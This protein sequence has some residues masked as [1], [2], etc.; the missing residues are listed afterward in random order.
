MTDG[1]MN[2]EIPAEAPVEADVNLT[3]AVTPK[4]V[5][6]RPDGVPEEFWDA[7]NGTFNNEKLWEDHQRQAKMAKDLRVKLSKGEQNVPEKADMY[8]VTLDEEFSK[9]I[10]A[11]DKGLA[12]ARQA[13]HEAGL[14]QAQFEGFVGKYLAGVKEMGLLTP[15]EA[16]EPSP[17]EIKAAFDAEVSKLGRDGALEIKANEDWILGQYRNGVFSKSD[18]EAFSSMAQTAE[19]VRAFTKLR[20]MMGE[21]RIPTSTSIDTEGASKVDIQSWV[22]DPRYDTDPAFRA[23]VEKKVAKAIGA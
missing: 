13:A 5:V 10:P 18:I 2:I 6:A 12:A 19:Q 16:V 14:S 23:Q 4:E 3:E 21:Q 15:Q 11:D 22:N 9:L 8:K 7:A 17:E 1:L 20:E